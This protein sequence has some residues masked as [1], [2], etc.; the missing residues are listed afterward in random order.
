MVNANLSEHEPHFFTK[1]FRGKFY[2]YIPE[3]YDIV[4]I[5]IVKTMVINSIMPYVSL[6]TGLGIPF[7]KRMIDK[8]F[9]MND[10]YSTKKTSMG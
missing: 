9:R 4:G 8:R 6:C 1:F 7:V 5:V 3:W 2:D 10:N